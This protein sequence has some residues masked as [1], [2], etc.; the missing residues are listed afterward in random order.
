MAIRA[1]GPNK[2]GVSTDT[3]LN[4]PKQLKYSNLMEKDLIE[5]A[6]MISIKE[7][8]DQEFEND[9]I[10]AKQKSLQELAFQTQAAIAEGPELIKLLK[11]K[12]QMS[13]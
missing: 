12:N 1:P 7:Y 9:L 4:T 5:T 8:K 6:T 13:M 3:S 2:K 11:G 10:L